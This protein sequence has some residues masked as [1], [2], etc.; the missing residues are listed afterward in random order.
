MELRLLRYF[1]AVAEELHFGRDAQRLHISQPPLSTQIRELEDEVGVPL[2]LRTKRSVQLTPA[3]RAFLA[4]ARQILD[5]TAQAKEVA[6][7]AD[8]K[9]AGR[10][11]VAC[12]PVAI[13]AAAPAVLANF[14]AHCPTVTVVLMETMPLGI[15]EGLQKGTVDVGLVVP[16]FDAVAVKREQILMLPLAVV[17]PRSHPLA[18]RGPIRLH[19]LEG[20]PLVLFSRGIGSGFTEHILGLFHWRGFTPK[21]AHEVTGI[22]ALFAMVAAGY[23]VSLVPESLAHL[24]G[25]SVA[26]VR[27][28]KP[29]PTIELCL[30]WRA[31]NVSPVLLTFLDLARGCF[32]ARAGEPTR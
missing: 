11:V 16:Y 28:Q 6:R 21:V 13:Y 26:F 32:P 14:R 22:Q 19:Q 24:A 9:E 23:G 30:A 15:V 5:R 25:L 12:G 18:E 1:V 7:R 20:E 8:S 2:L 3:G 27:F 4:E 17:V 31:N 29:K 10:L